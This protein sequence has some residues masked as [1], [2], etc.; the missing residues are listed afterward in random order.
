MTSSN[1]Y[2][3]LYTTICVA[4]FC[5]YGTV[6]VFYLYGTMRASRIINNKLMDSVFG[7]TL[8]CV[9]F[10]SHHKLHSLGY[11][12]LDETPTGRIITRST[13]DIQAVDGP[14]P[15]I[16][17]V[18]LDLLSGMVTKLGAIVLFTPL[19]LIPGVGVAIFGFFLA[20]MYLKAQ[21]SVKRETRYA[22]GVVRKV[23][24]AYVA[25]SNARSP[26]LAHFNEAIHG[27]G[28]YTSEHW[29]MA[30]TF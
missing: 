30:M 11:R 1:S 7:S 20:K 17:V 13:Q 26:M 5:V 19:F 16:F 15:Q 29:P 6:Y 21:L 23:T 12:W 22:H 3:T 10:L 27:I 2:L 28:M 25:C 4:S 18:L 14:I 9:S 24:I 8:Q